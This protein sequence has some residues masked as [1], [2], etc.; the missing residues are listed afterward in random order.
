[1]VDFDNPDYDRFPRFAEAERNALGVVLEPGDVIYIPNMWWHQVESLSAI[2]GLVI[3]G[4]R[5]RPEYTA[6]L[7]RH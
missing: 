6:H 2:N 3:S 1:M 7:L 5:R 4:G